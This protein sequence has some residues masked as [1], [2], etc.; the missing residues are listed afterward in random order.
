MKL[1]KAGN[2]DAFYN[3]GGHYARGEGM[4]RDLAKAN[5]LYLK[6]NPIECSQSFGFS[7]DITNNQWRFM[8]IHSLS[9]EE[10]SI[11]P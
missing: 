11:Q 10:I 3:F 2:A 8:L 5:E 7:Y 6:S 1:I 4:P 9:W